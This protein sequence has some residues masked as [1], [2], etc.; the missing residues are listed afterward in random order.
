VF[1]KKSCSLGKLFWYALV[2]SKKNETNSLRMQKMR[3]YLVAARRHRQASHL[4][5]MQECALGSWAGCA[6]A[7]RTNEGKHLSAAISSGGGLWRAWRNSFEN[8][9]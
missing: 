6:G 1:K 8:T 4:P 2:G 9:A 3:A 5:K 7:K